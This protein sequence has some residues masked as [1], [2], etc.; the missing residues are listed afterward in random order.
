MNGHS[1]RPAPPEE[2]RHGSDLRSYWQV[3][4]R[5]KWTLALVTLLCVAGAVGY[6]LAQQDKYTASAE[7]LL[8]APGSGAPDTGGNQSARPPD[9]QT[10]MRIV[11][12]TQVRTAVSKKLGA[13][14]PSISVSPIGQTNLIDIS[15]TNASPRSAALVSNEY[16]QAYIDYKRTQVVDNLLA[17]ADQVQSR[18]NALDGQVAT[19][20]RAGSKSSSPEVQAVLTQEITF[21]MQLA[22]L[23]VNG[24]L[25][26]GGAQLVTPAVAP[27]R[28][29]SPRPKRNGTLGLGVGLI[30]GVGAAFLR[31]YLDDRVR[32]E[33]DLRCLVPDLPVLASIP[34]MEAWKKKESPYLVTLSLPNSAVAEAYRGLR[35][36]LQF[37]GLDKSI[38]TV[39][40]TSPLTGEGK[41]TTLA[42]LAV[43]M[44][45]AGERVVVV[46]CDLRRPRLNRFFGV[47]DKV[48]FTT[49][50]LDGVSV[51]QALQ[52]VADVPNLSVIASGA[53]PPNPSELLGG[54]RT[55]QV[56]QDLRE[57]FD[58]VLIDSPPILPVTDATVLSG[59]VDATLLV[60]RALNT[61]HHGITKALDTLAQVRA[62]VV[63]IVLNGEVSDTRGLGKSY[64]YA[65]YANSTDRSDA[66]PVP[67]AEIRTSLPYR[68]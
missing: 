61:T 59:R 28:P 3:L 23:Q 32:H 65:Y 44:A 51:D 10:E 1:T 39:Q 47:D 68:R 56:L 63:G 22:Q 38:R 42:N 43:M 29:S 49:L 8:Q 36:S 48:G 24:A 27:S 18:I 34:D 46:C 12:S 21:K 19:L 37:I 67:Q 41:T 5:R 45:Q 16:A 57:R 31:E 17:A 33:D 14:S 15:Y 6:A 11:T 2:L 9:V 62:P 40:V 52:P 55:A 58:I 60:V 26:N 53:I 66:S 4:R 35:T 7:V 64:R 30:F 54:P 50:L 13:P 25:A 20:E